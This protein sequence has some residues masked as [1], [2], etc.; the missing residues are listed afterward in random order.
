M[1][2][3]KAKAG[4]GGGKGHPHN[5]GA[6]RSAA[7]ARDEE[8]DAEDGFGGDE[9]F[10]RLDG[11]RNQEDTDDEEAFDLAGSDLDD[12]DDD[13]DGAD[14]EVCFRVRDLCTAGG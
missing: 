10:V 13:E 12:S 4:S 1:A 7:P 8:V 11:K 14:E 5:G 9:S 3:S 6:R 2:R